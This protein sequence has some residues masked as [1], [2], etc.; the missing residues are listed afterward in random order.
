MKKKLIMAIVSAAALVFP[1]VATSAPALACASAPS[2]VVS[3]PSSGTV[4]VRIT[5]NSCNVGV[6]SM[7][8]CNDGKTYFGGDVKAVNATTAVTCPGGH[9]VTTAG[10]R[11]WDGSAWHTVG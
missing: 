4:S 6:E 11:W 5:A 7:A 9:L 1:F 3:R 8:K 2:V 10:Y